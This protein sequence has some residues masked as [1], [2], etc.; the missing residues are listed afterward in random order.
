MNIFISYLKYRLCNKID[1]LYYN[2]TNYTIMSEAHTNT[3]ESMLQSKHALNGKELNKQYNK[4]PSWEMKNALRELNQK[5]IKNDPTIKKLKKECRE[6]A[7]EGWVCPHCKK[8]VRRLTSAHVGEPVC[9]IIDRILEEHYPQ[10][11]LHE[12]YSILR[13]KHDD[14]RIVVCCDECNKLLEDLKC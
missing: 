11:N 3:K 13:T 4:S 6:Q 7:T 10:K 1:S 9:K 8:E 14:I 12:L 5:R 2:K